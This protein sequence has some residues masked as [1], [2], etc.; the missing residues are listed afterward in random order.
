LHTENDDIT[1]YAE[2][3]K[4][5]NITMG[6]MDGKKLKYQIVDN[7]SRFKTLINWGWWRI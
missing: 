6:K 7:G 1:G 2:I 3:L 5:K 4:A